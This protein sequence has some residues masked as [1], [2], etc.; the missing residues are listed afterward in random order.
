LD[1]FEVKNDTSSSIEETVVGAVEF[2]LDENLARLLSPVVIVVW[3]Y[4][5]DRLSV[6]DFPFL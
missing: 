6:D 5:D 1:D 4:V 2:D 3:V